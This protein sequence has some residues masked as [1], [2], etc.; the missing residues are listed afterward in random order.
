[1]RKT[2]IICTIG[3]V[4]DNIEMLS[5]LVAAGMNVVRLNMS[6]GTHESHAHV[7]SAINKLNKTL[8]SYLLDAKATEAA[9]MLSNEGGD[10]AA[11]VQKA[12]VKKGAEP[13]EQSHLTH[14]LTEVG[15]SFLDYQVVARRE[16]E[17]RNELSEVPALTRS[18]PYFAEDI[19]SLGGLIR[20]GETIWR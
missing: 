19:H 3:P 16:A 4:T 12:F 9:K 14:V 2:K 18:V 17:Q 11:D 10:V 1:M 6:H 15:R 13:P 8:P 20:L 7:I 5:R